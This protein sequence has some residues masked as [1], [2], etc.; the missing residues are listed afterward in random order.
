MDTGVR[1]AVIGAWRA[2]FDAMIGQGRE[3]EVTLFS[4]LVVQEFVFLGRKL[5][6]ARFTSCDQTDVKRVPAVSAL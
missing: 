2:T 4:T 1:I 5:R 3:N 6:Q